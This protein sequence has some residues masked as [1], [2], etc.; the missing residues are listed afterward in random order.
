MADTYNTVNGTR[1]PQ[2]MGEELKAAGWGGDVNN[3][4]SV[5]NAYA[6]TTRGSATP[7]GGQWP[8]G[9][10]GTGT[11]T[12]AG[13]GGAAAGGGSAD[14]LGGQIDKLLAAIAGGNKQAFDETVREFNQTFGLDQ[15][16]FNEA[17][18]QFNQNFPIAQAALTGS[19]QGAPTLAA[20]AQNA[21]LYGLNGT[22]TPGE[23]TLAA[24]KQYADLYGGAGAAPAAGATTLAAQQQ[25]YAQQMGVINAAATLQANPFRQAQV[26]GQAGQV[27]ANNP[28][29]GFSAPNTVAGVGTA[30]GNTQGGMGYLQQMIDD[31]RSP[32][33]NQ[34][35]A[36][37]FLGQT[38]T[39]NKLDSVSFMKSSPS[40]QN[41]ILQAMQEKYG[42]DPKDAAQQITNTM[43]QF[44]APNT[45]GTVRR[46]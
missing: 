31:I 15:A 20:Q 35:T 27:L 23:Q 10:Q 37:A 32:Q 3:V 42:I 34:T 36:D 14:A 30:G 5:V 25:A 39:P 24:Q 40:T 17:T 4:Q 22:P 1:T 43:P 11:G 18:R 2:Q 12:G 29:A 7:Q 46:G 13:T 19:Y 21:G 44:T 41:L 28:V 45:V 16:K 38:P 26:L 6:T 9:G 33:A 8:G